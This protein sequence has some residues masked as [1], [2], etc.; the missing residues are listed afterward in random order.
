[1]SKMMLTAKDMALAK[2]RFC[3]RWAKSDPA[4]ATE[5]LRTAAAWWNVYRT[6]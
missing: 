4:R 1:M 2:A 5:H 3:E 6:A